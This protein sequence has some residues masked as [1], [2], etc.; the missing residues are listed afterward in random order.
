MEGT[1]N[2][3]FEMERLANIERASPFAQWSYLVFKLL[4]Y[5]S[6]DNTNANAPKLPAGA[7]CELAEH[8]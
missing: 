8:L 4:V 6:T 5:C 2:A 1:L 3:V 7:T